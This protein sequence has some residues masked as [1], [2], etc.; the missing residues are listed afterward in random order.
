MVQ[1]TANDP[2]HVLVPGYFFYARPELTYSNVATAT[3]IP[4]TGDGLEFTL[5]D[6]KVFYGPIIAGVD[7][8]T[9]WFGGFELNVSAGGTLQ[10]TLKTVHSFNG[11]SFTHSR[12]H[13][14]DLD[15]NNHS[16]FPLNQFSRIS[17]VN[18]GSQTIGGQAVTL[19]KADANA[20]ATISY[21]LE[22]QLWNNAF[23]ARKAGNVTSLRWEEP[24]TVSS[25]VTG[26]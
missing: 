11:K 20:D 24:Q 12:N 18:L 9:E 15:T 8:R 7:F 22:L 14:V 2:H 17:K 21:I 13:R 23:T 16:F 25:Q 10:V 4:T 3:A 6:Q 1:P 26:T 5:L 19:N